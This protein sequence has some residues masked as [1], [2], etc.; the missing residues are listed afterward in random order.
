MTFLVQ[1]LLLLSFRFHI[2]LWEKR[3]LGWKGNY[4]KVS[5][6]TPVLSFQRVSAMPPRKCEPF[7]TLAPKKRLWGRKDR[8][9]RNMVEFHFLWE[10]PLKPNHK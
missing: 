6:L 9:F 10:Y 1:K 3:P 7:L 4:T 5:K 2:I 8:P